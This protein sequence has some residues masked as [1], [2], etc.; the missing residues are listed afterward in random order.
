MK[1]KVQVLAPSEEFTT[2][3]GN[4]SYRAPC[5]FEDVGARFPVGRGMIYSARSLPVGGVEAVLVSY[6]RGEARL[7][8]RENR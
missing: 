1:V 8:L 3:S 4:K 7:A 2:K 6:D 5:S